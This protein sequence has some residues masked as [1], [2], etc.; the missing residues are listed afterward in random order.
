MVVAVVSDLLVLVDT[1]EYRD[2]F[3]KIA[4]H[5]ITQGPHARLMDT[6]T[7]SLITFV[8][9]NTKTTSLWI[10]LAYEMLII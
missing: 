9:T 2:L 6:L 1:A 8:W 5:Q 3:K 4:W 7:L 10:G